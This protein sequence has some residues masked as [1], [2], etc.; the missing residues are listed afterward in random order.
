MKELVDESVTN[1]NK[2]D[3]SLITSGRVTLLGKTTFDEE[4]QSLSCFCLFLELIRVEPLLTL[5]TV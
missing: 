3:P 5:S 4:L 2:D 1:V